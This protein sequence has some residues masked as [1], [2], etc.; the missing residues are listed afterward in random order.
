MKRTTHTIVTATFDGLT[1]EVFL[2]P[3]STT[4]AEALAKAKAII[5]EDNKRSNPDTEVTDMI[6]DMQ[7]EFAVSGLAT[8]IDTREAT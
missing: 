3:T 1:T 8:L 4:E 6:I 2:F 5:K 7:Y